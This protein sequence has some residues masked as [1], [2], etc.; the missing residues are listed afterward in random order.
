MERPADFV[1]E[2]FHR[3]EEEDIPENRAIP[4]IIQLPAGSLT[5]VLTEEAIDQAVLSLDIA[6]REC[7]ENDG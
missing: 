3:D 7:K 6:L 1:P 5:A 4:E 2:L